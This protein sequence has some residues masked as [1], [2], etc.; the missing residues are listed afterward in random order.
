M[1]YNTV[2]E[3]RVQDAVNQIII[4]GTTKC[5]KSLCCTNKTGKSVNYKRMQEEAKDKQ[6]TSLSTIF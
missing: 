2:I 5:R 6:N 3:I 1:K 4:L